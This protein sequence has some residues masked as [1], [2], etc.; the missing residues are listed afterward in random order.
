[1]HANKIKNVKNNQERRMN[2]ANWCEL[3][4]WQKGLVKDP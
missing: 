4:L 3:Y 2:P 1:L